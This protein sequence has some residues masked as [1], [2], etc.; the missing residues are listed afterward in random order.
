MSKYDAVICGGGQNGLSAAAYL[1]KAGLSVCVLEARDFIGGGAIS[2]EHPEAPGVI[3]DPCASIHALIQGNPL[4][5]N[6]ELGLKANYGL[7]YKLF[8]A[9]FTEVFLD[10]DFAIT[11]W[12]DIDKTCEE[13]AK[14]LGQKEADNY[15]NMM[16]TFAPL[17]A[18][19]SF[20]T[21]SPP[22]PSDD[23]MRDAFTTMGEAGALL[24]RLSTMS[25]WDVCCEYLE[26]DELREAICR[27]VSEQMV[28]PYDPGTGTACAM[29]CGYLHAGGMPVCIGGSQKLSDA[30]A[31]FIIDHGGVIRTNAPVK[32]V[33]IE[34]GVAKAFIL[35]DGEEVEAEKVLLATVHVKQV[36]GEGGF[37]D[38]SLL[39]DELKD[40]V[41][42]LR[43]SLFVALNQNLTIREPL[44]YKLL[45]DQVNPAASVEQST[46][47]ADF[48]GMFKG[49]ET[50]QPSP[51]ESA[52]ALITTTLDPDRGGEEGYHTLYLYS[53]EPYALYGDPANWDKYGQKIADEKLDALKEITTN[54]TD[55][56]IVSRQIRNPL[57]F[58]RF[59]AS[60]IGGDFCHISQ[61][62]D[63][64]MTTRPVKELSRYKTPFE[65]LY[66]GGA[67]TW[68]GPTVSGGGRA[69][70]QLI[71]E[72]LGISFDEV[73]MS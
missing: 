17:S 48:E 73:V 62:G 3:H 39:S 1:A 31:A 57:D 11:F 33:K 9:G 22:A 13:I 42:N 53:Y 52:M 36:F 60:W 69:V 5:L 66:I 23:A 21:F 15:R 29:M 43:P 68:P 46:G 2:E 44:R 47:S 55:D 38:Q 41:N 50:G 7:E 65:H 61:D 34:D 58:E 4:V 14:H 27:V 30:L 64:G 67:S 51:R 25:A 19:M 28:S 54:L 45:G 72:D 63:Q 56:N 35:E 8:D 10:K 40:K 18:M 71:F 49:F 37:V 24:A 12:V 26:S 6:D 20:G 32:G 59:N 70:A 16:E